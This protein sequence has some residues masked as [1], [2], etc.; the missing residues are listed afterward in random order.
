MGTLGLRADG[1]TGREAPTPTKG[2]TAE[3]RSTEARVKTIALG[4]GLKN[5]SPDGVR[6]AH[7]EAAKAH[8]AAA[9]AHRAEGNKAEAEHHEKLAAEHRE[10]SVSAKP[11]QAGAEIRQMQ[12]AGLRQLEAAKSGGGGGDQPR[13][14]KGQFSSK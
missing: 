2:P 13:D 3:D 6:F 14:E 11:R 1:S 10:A 7:G 5:K 4:S 8:D 12:S 9:A